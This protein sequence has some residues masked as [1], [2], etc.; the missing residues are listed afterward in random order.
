[1]NM[2][3]KK[4]II[5]ASP[6]SGVEEVKFGMKRDEVRAI[7]GEAKEFKKNKFSKNTTDDL[8]FCHV[9]YTG[10]DCCEAIELF[11]DVKVLIDNKKVF[12]T[13]IQEAKA[14]IGDMQ[15]DDSK[16]FYTNK[17]MSVSICMNSDN[18]MESILFGGKG[19]Y[20]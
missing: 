14:V 20:D 12:P 19:Y 2:L 15:C 1:M 3:N 11:N 10:D 6:L 8:G 13:T 16:T 17:E 18:T 4:E 7:F 5:S 9:Y